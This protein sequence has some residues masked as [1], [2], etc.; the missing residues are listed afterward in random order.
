[1]VAD[2]WRFRCRDCLDGVCSEVTL[3]LFGGIF[4]AMLEI[5][6][7]DVFIIEGMSIVERVFMVKT[8]FLIVGK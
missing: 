6:V 7:W 8:V 5:S 1:M 4:Y 3:D 2:I